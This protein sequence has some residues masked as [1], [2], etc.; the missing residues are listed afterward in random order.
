MWLLGCILKSFRKYLLS[1]SVLLC[2]YC[3]HLPRLFHYEIWLGKEHVFF[4][5]MA[6]NSLYQTR[7]LTTDKVINAI[8]ADDDF[9][10]EF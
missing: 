8:F 7:T 9:G 6:S 4:F 5:K 1:I 3:V 10:D 2:E